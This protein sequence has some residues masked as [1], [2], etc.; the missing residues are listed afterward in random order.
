[1]TNSNSTL[2]DDDSTRAKKPMSLTGLMPATEVRSYNDVP[3]YRK[4]EFALFPLLMPLLILVVLTGDVFHGATTTM[5]EYSD[6]NV[7]RYSAAAR[8]FFG[9]VGAISMIVMATLLMRFL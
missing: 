8:T 2:A 3:W 9:V 4:Q 5:K 6:A 7:W 1:M